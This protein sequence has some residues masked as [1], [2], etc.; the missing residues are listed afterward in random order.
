KFIGH[1][2]YER[3]ESSQG[4]IFEAYSKKPI[5][6]KSSIRSSSQTFGT[7]KAPV[8]EP[9]ENLASSV[10]STIQLPPIFN[11]AMANATFQNKIKM[12]GESITNFYETELK[13][14]LAKVNPSN[15]KAK[16]ACV[17]NL[18]AEQLTPNSETM[19]KAAKLK[20]NITKEDVAFTYSK[21]NFDLCK[22]N[23]FIW[24]SGGSS[25]V[26]SQIFNQFA[27]ENP[28]IL[29]QIFADQTNFGCG[30]LVNW[31]TQEE[32]TLRDTN[33]ELIANLIDKGYILPK[34]KENHFKYY[35][36]FNT[37]GKPKIM[38]LSTSDGYIVPAKLSCANLVPLPKPIYL[39]YLFS[40]MPSLCGRK[41]NFDLNGAVAW[42]C[43][44]RLESV[45]NTYKKPWKNIY[46]LLDEKTKK[47]FINIDLVT[48]IF[49][50]NY[51]D[52]INGQNTLNEIAFKKQMI[53][54]MFSD[55]YSLP[56]SEADIPKIIEWSKK[57]AQLKTKEDSLIYHKAE[58]NYK[59][60]VR[61]AVRGWILMAKERGIK[62]FIGGAI[63]CGA[64]AND[65]NV[66][67]KIIAQEFIKFG[68]D[69]T[70]VYGAFKGAEDPILKIFENEFKIAF[71]NKEDLKDKHGIEEEAEDE[72]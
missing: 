64:F 41:V 67:A 45:E 6:K 51:S 19:Q 5:L 27:K 35:D 28:K 23:P 3:K 36:G 52:R 37:I 63:G 71:E 33:P 68:G 43:K 14:R 70:Y 61:K 25:Q 31:N 7:E 38:P 56:K 40:S 72:I 32:A 49:Q 69:M 60:T 58:N 42:T 8:L 55:K 17:T 10:R 39:F 46:L 54:L 62:Y 30:L 20:L 11:A 15:N 9:K 4:G 47:M 53:L 18:I 48:K 2:N 34:D 24:K 26:A 12:F 50:K 22:K 59:K 57:V 1:G 21:L 66:I 44:F 13:N 29:V 16:I 65:P